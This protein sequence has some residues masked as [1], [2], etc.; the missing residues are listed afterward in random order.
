MGDIGRS[1][2]YEG[3]V[4]H[5]RFS[6]VKNAFRYR[7]FLMYIDLA[8]LPEVFDG[9]PLWSARRWALA[10]FRRADYHGPRDVP[11]DV[12]VRDTVEKQTG[13]RPQGPIDRKSVV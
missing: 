4:R 9:Y 6:P 1:C 2:V 11:L 13:V 7:I 12:A 10:W 8:A 3:W 5:R